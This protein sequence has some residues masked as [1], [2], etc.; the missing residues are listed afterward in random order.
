MAKRIIVCADGTWN[1]PGEDKDADGKL[2][3]KPHTNVYKIFA[4]LAGEHTEGD[5][6]D[7]EQEKQLKV[8]G[9]TTQVAKYIHGVG[10]STNPLFRAIGGA[11]GAGVIT[12]IVRGYT[13][14]SRHYDEGDDII[15]CGF[16]R[17]AYTARALGG[18][19][20]SQ[21]V[22]KKHLTQDKEDAYRR[23][24]AAWRRYRRFD[25]SQSGWKVWVEW[26]SNLGDYIRQAKLADDDLLAV[27]KIAAIGV[28]D[29]V[30]AL[31]IPDY[32]KDDHGKERID[33]FQFADTRLSD[34]VAKGF[35]AVALDEQRVDFTPTWWDSADRISQ[36]AFPGAHSDV[37]GG[38][39]LTN[40]ESGLSDIALDWMQCN[41]Q[42]CGVEF[43]TPICAAFAPK[44]NGPA[45]Q[46]WASKSPLPKGPRDLRGKGVVAHASILER[47][48][49]GPVLAVPGGVPA[50]YKP[51]GFL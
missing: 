27:P 46:P 42:S 30:G 16:S 6:D 15:L 1:G 13:F 36:V 41:F 7:R 49:A 44:A 28:W 26:L 35:H 32:V 10:N 3:G 39:P 17:G 29:T 31:G 33:T 40:D 22:L 24:T 8:G 19:I 51:T 12:R 14:V 48:N 23:G 5:A 25:T 2:D 43:L 47:Q 37:G 11:F 50:P 34:K 18:L 9:Q 45:H 20:A 4:G 21:G 38:Y